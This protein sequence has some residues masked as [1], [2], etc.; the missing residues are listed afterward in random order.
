MEQYYFHNRE[1][2]Q[3]I[4]YLKQELSFRD[5]ECNELAKQLA[6]MR[7]KISIDETHEES[8]EEVDS[9]KKELQLAAEREN[10]L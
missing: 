7:E 9:L 6:D 8:E 10:R 5:Q 3:E 4:D 1:L 2:M